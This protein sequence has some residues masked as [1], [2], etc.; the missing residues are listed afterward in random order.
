[1]IEE[2]LKEYLLGD[3]VIDRIFILGNL[4]FF[5]SWDNEVKFWIF[6][7]DR[8]L[9]F[10]KIYK[11]IIEEDKFVLKNYD[12]FVCVKMVIKLCLGEKEILEKVVKSVV[13]NWEYYC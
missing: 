5:V 8:V 1:M 10:L 3:S 2:E 7:E 9:F 12:F 6:F 13:V 4:E 11:I